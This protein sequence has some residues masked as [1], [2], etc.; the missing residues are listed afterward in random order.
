MPRA[1]APATEPVTRTMAGPASGPPPARAVLD[2]PSPWPGRLIKLALVAALAYGAYAG[3][4][5]LTRP[6]VFR[7]HSPYRSSTGMTLDLPGSSGWRTDRRLRQKQS[8]GSGWMRADVVFRGPDARNADDFVVVLRVH[9]PGGFSRAIDPESLR[10]GLERSLQQS[11]LAAG[12]TA[13]NL[14]CVHESTWR[15]EQ[16]VACYGRFELPY[17]E[18]PVGVY[19][20]VASDDDVVGI[21]YA[22]AD[23][24]LDPLAAM[25]RTAR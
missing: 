5:R 10:G 8:Q 2:D 22:T 7:V 16:A 25:A 15:T 9:M 1:T 20:W 11:A 19:L 12:A 14:A 3:Y 18:L 17:R 13:R 24:T 4:R 23:G 6:D 21:G